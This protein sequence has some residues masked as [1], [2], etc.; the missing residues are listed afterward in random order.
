MVVIDIVRHAEGWHNVAV[1]N[2]TIQ[3]PVL[4]DRG[5]KQCGDLRATY[6][7]GQKLKMLVASPMQRTLQTCILSFGALAPHGAVVVAIPELQELSTL[8]SDVGSDPAVLQKLFGE[9]VDFSRV[10]PGWNNKSP[11]TPFEPSI[12]KIEARA[13]KAR[14]TL[15]ELAAHLAE[16][17]HIVVV[18]HGAF[19]HFL[20]ED[21]YGIPPQR[22]T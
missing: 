4:T 21:Y 16:D 7:H 20:T 22:G 13:R 6:P 15:R 10:K 9:Q 5:E 1:E 19:L 17:D 12:P 14:R 3:D 8:P 18:S 2:Q 11:S